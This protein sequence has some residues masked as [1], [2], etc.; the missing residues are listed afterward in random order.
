MTKDAKKKLETAGRRL[1]R[2]GGNCKGCDKCRIYTG[3]N[4]K[5]LYYAFGCDL[6]PCDYFGCI[7]DTMTGLHSEAVEVVSFEL[8]GVL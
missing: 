3:G 8:K 4:D 7:S 2:C 6:L 1:A 5:A